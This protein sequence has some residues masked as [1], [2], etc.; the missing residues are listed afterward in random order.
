MRNQSQENKELKERLLLKDLHIAELRAAKDQIENKY[1]DFYEEKKLFEEKS[2]KFKEAITERL[3]KEKNHIE[4][5]INKYDFQNN[6]IVE[7]KSINR[8]LHEEV[9]QNQIQIKQFKSN[10]K[11]LESER[12]DYR[13]ENSLL[14]ERIQNLLNELEQSEQS[15]RIKDN[16]I[17]ILS[18]QLSNSRNDIE[19]K[20]SCIR[21]LK[22]RITN[23]KNE[24]N[25]KNNSKINFADNQQLISLQNAL[26]QA[27]ESIAA[28]Q[29][30]SS[31]MESEVSCFF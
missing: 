6:Q 4:E 20:D 22:D 15:N 5:L 18:E 9:E 11:Q 3:E 13:Q 31:F 12:E 1:S 2:N 14:E 23:Q 30:H 10:I 8:S 16:R 28:H 26:N 29:E 7:L 17:E 21:S 19:F 25:T 24:I 27:K